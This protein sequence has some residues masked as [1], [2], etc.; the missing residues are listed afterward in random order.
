MDG[1]KH[2]LSSSRGYTIVYGCNK[3]HYAIPWAV[4][5]AGRNGHDATRYHAL[6]LCMTNAILHHSTPNFSVTECLAPILTDNSVP[7]PRLSFNECSAP[8][9]LAIGAYPN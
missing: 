3:M 2:R 6:R 8:I 7:F 9:S 5:A 1:G 4:V